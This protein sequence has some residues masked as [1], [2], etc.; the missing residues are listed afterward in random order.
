MRKIRVNSIAEQQLKR[1]K[2]TVIIT[3]PTHFSVAVKYELGMPA[4]IV[5]AKGA[6]FLALKM[7]GC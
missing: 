7:R 5:L 2:A 6:D 4:P 3:N 1:H